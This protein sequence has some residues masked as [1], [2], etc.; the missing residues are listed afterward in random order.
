MASVGDTVTDEIK[1]P[2]LLGYC[3]ALYDRFLTEH[4]VEEVD[5]EELQVWRGKI[6]VTARNVGIPDGVYKRVMDQLHNLYCIEQIERGYRGNYPTTVVLLRPPTAEVW[7]D[8]VADRGLTRRD[9]AAI[10][11]RRLSDLERR[12]GTLDIVKALGELQQQIDDLKSK[13]K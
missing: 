10:L 12:L 4:T 11:S 2:K 3:T 6:T 9:G 8:E 1:Q 13:V 5:G 7:E